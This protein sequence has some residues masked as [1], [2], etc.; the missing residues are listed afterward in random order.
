[1]AGRAR[2]AEQPATLLHSDF[3]LDNVVLDPATLEPVP[4]STG[5]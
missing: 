5:T 4:C 3:K 2:A 1:M